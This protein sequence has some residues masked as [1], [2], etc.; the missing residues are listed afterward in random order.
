MNKEW[1]DFVHKE[2]E[3]EDAVQIISEKLPE[4]GGRRQPTGGNSKKGD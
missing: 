1:I 4:T 3:K 2:K